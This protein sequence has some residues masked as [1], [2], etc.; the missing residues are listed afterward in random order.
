[1]D[2]RSSRYLSS[3]STS[4]LSMRILIVS[5]YFWPEEFRIN[6]LALNLVKRGNK[7]TVLTGNPNYP[8]GSF[9]K[10]YG[11]KSS[12]D[13]YKGIKIHRVPIIPRG[14]NEFTLILN[15]LSF[16][17]AG[18]LFS[19]FHKDKYDKILAVNLSPITAVIPA[20]VSKKHNNTPLF[21]WVQ[22]LWPESVLAA[23]RFR[24]PIIQKLL[25]SLVKYIYKKSDKILVSNYGF[26]DSILAKGVSKDK[27]SVMPNWAEEIFEDQT[28]IGKTKYRSKMPDGFIVMFAGNVGEAQ[29][30]ESILNA[31]LLT[32]DLKH[33]K[34]VIVGDGR[35]TEWLKIEIEKRNLSDTF[36]V[37]GRFPSSEMPNFF[38]HADLML[39]SL[40]N[41]HIFSLTVPTK[42]QS[43]MEF[44]KPI[45]T[46]LNGA[47]SLIVKEANCGYR[48]NAR[49][50]KKL[51]ENIIK[52]SLSSKEDLEQLGKNGRVYYQANFAKEK[53]INDFIN[54]LN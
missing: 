4:I 5:Q 30:F 46:M 44:G 36:F 9:Y 22:D 3:L 40:K 10:G 42:V 50:Y 16:V 11:F 31:A 32:M 35:K 26:I 12:I 47:G 14:Q 17:L 2:V 48:A 13:N 6:D 38:C 45:V 8:K 15:Y 24:N 18:S 43:Y 21:I 19:F 34:W 39:V 51:S 23:S 28:N 29:D 33:I 53:V 37:L 25:L 27:I 41:E 1:M 52:A 54:V 20:I 7:V 49:D